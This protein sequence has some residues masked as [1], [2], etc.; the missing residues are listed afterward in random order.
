MSVG[1]F[2][3]LDKPSMSASSVVHNQNVLFPTTDKQKQKS[4]A[5]V[6][7]WE[8]ELCPKLKSWQKHELHRYFYCQIFVAEQLPSQQYTDC[9]WRVLWRGFDKYD[10]EH[11]VHLCQY[12]SSMTYFKLTYTRASNFIIFIYFIMLFLE[13]A[14]FRFNYA[15]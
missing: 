7:R 3:Q 1:Q 10:H 11:T 15:K 12:I 5:V 9:C 8:K 14:V 6:R 2:S 13:T 4:A